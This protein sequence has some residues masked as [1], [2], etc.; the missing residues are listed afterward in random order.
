MPYQ[1]D[2]DPSLPG[3][4]E[5][6]TAVLHT[7]VEPETHADVGEDEGRD[8]HVAVTLTVTEEV[9]YGFPVNVEVPASIATDHGALHDYLACNEDLW[10]DDLD[11]TGANSCL[12]INERS[13][14]GVSMTSPPKATAREL[15]EASPAPQDS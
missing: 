14:D 2:K 4:A 7:G 10:L 11:P 12:Y 15:G 8:V 9:T 6:A 5:T 3:E 13:L 1:C